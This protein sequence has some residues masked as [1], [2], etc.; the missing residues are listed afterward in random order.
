M[1]GA[2]SD[3]SATVDIAILGG[4]VAGLWS[5]NRLRQAGYNAILIESSSLVQGRLVMPRGLFMVV[6]SMPLQV[7]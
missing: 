3:V 1:S 7:R 2:M 5:L 6:P 4:G